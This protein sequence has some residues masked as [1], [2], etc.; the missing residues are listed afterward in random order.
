MNTGIDQAYDV[1]YEDIRIN[2]SYLYPK[3][4][5]QCKVCGMRSDDSNDFEEENICHDCYMNE[6]FDQIDEIMAEMDRSIEIIN[7]TI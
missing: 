6:L 1:A 4:E 3:E 2:H 5:Y 7:E